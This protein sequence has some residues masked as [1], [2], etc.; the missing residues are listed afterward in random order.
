MKGMF[1]Y[2]YDLDCDGVPMFVSPNQFVSLDDDVHLVHFELASFHDA[3]FYSDAVKC[4]IHL[5][6]VA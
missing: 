3:Y 1:T 5:L 6:L 2:P 4:V